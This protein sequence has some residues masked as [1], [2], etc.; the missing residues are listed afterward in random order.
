MRPNKAPQKFK[1]GLDQK[2][3]KFDRLPLKKFY[4][5]AFLISL[6]VALIALISRF[7]LPPEIPLFYGLPQSNQQLSSS[8]YLFLPSLVSIIFTSINAYTSTFIDINYL[9]KVFAFSSL[10]VSILA[11]ITT[12][13]IIFLVGHI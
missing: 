2:K 5:A 1:K 9:K 7:I 3:E 8:V 10:I 13:K 4:I 11:S 6:F 12:L